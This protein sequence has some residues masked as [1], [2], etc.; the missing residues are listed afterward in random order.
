MAV[1]SASVIIF[2]PAVGGFSLVKCQSKGKISEWKLTQMTILYFLQNRP[3]VLAMASQC[4]GKE[5]TALV[6]HLPT[7]HLTVKM[8]NFTLVPDHVSKRFQLIQPWWLGG[9][10]VD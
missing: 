10:A 5:R 4:G 6:T 3:T 9:R 7:W 8:L 1:R 2:T